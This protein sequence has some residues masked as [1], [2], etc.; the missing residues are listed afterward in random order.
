[1]TTLLQP[2]GAATDVRVPVNVQVLNG[3]GAGHAEHRQ[4]LLTISR[5]FWETPSASAAPKWLSS[6]LYEIRIGL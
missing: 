2:N 6:L 5:R 4:T 3:K 1:M